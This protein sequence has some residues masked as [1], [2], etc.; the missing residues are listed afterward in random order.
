M[1]VVAVSVAV[2]PEQMV[3][4]ETVIVGDGF[5]VIV[6]G[7]NWLGHPPPPPIGVI[8]TCPFPPGLPPPPTVL[9]TLVTEGS[10]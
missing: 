3:T 8:I 5:T 1:F 7:V 4:P 2:C 6:T 9:E 10:A